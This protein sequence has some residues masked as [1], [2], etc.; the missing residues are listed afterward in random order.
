MHEDDKKIKSNE[1]ENNFQFTKKI[2]NP[3]SEYCAYLAPLNGVMNLWISTVDSKESPTPLTRNTEGDIWDV[4]WAT[5][6]ILYFVHKDKKGV[7]WIYAINL[8]ISN[9]VKRIAEKY[10]YEQMV[11]SMLPIVRKFYTS[12]EYRN[13][14]IS[15]LCGWPEINDSLM[16]IDTELSFDFYDELPSEKKE[17]Y[18]ESMCWV[19]IYN[20]LDGYKVEPEKWQEKIAYFN[21]LWLQLGKRRCETLEKRGA[22]QIYLMDVP[23]NIIPRGR[24]AISLIHEAILEE[25]PT[26]YLS[27]RKEEYIKILNGYRKAHLF[28]CKNDPDDLLWVAYEQHHCEISVGFGRKDIGMSLRVGFPW[29][30]NYPIYRVYS[31]TELELVMEKL[32][33]LLKF[34][35]PY[36]KKFFGDFHR[37]TANK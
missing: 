7:S 17:C 11:A 32:C 9:E 30:A 34:A 1:D 37:F 3:Y 29:A 15:R 18:L 28:P 27:S 8:A 26:R 19:Y 2:L 23:K 22:P 4:Y 6:A 33:S 12:T 14:V 10:D 35:Y 25:F 20:I 13:N 16:K 24:K 5:G 36:H 21:S 31:F